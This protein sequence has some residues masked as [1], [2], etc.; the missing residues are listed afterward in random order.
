MR[1]LA[2]RVGGRGEG[3]DVARRPSSAEDWPSMSAS[4]RV[5]V[6][7][8]SGAALAGVFASL[9]C[10]APALALPNPALLPDGRNWELVS[11]PD[12]H[13]ATI[14]PLGLGTEGPQ[15][16][17]VQASED[18]SRL[19]Y[20]ASA[21]I[22]GEPEGNRAP[23]G[24]QLLSTRGANAWSTK[25][26]ITPHTNAEGLPSG[27]GQEYKLFSPDLSLGLVQPALLHTL[28]EPPLTEL[29]EGT[30]TEEGSIYLRGPKCEANP[31][32]CYEAR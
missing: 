29:P 25:D 10:G 24:V 1:T 23:E 31:V 4:A 8:C 2:D 5:R 16:G 32:R 27:R 14:Q 17:L 11:P 3:V 30:T 21:P 19:T 28:Q 15:G 9:V 13:G 22:E 18:G 7:T 26:I 6:R 20:Q 12:K